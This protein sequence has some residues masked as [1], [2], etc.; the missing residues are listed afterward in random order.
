[1]K[2]ALNSVF[3]R[4]AGHAEHIMKRLREYKPAQGEGRA[5]NIFKDSLVY[6]IKELAELLPGLNI[7]GDVR[8]D[9]LQEQ[10]LEQ[11]VSNPPEILRADDK[12]RASTANKAE[13]ILKKVKSFMA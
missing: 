10:L 7:T 11:L 2:A 4:I 9:K 3:E 8:I 5:D 6:N 12:V 1:V 13:E